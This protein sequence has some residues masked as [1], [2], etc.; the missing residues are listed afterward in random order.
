V[1]AH[2]SKRAGTVDQS[3]APWDPYATVTAR[4]RVVLAEDS[5]LVREG[6]RRILDTDPDIEL[7]SSCVDLDGLLA[8]VERDRPHVVV[9]D[10]RMPPGN[11]DEG[12][13]AAARLRDAH[14]EVGVVVLSQHDE[15]EYALRLF[16]KGSARRAYLLKDSLNDPARLTGAV[17][18][19]ARGGSVVDPKVVE[20]LVEARARQHDSRIQELTERERDVLS[21]MAQGRNNDTIAERLHLSVRMVEKHINS[22]FSKL[23]LSEELDVHRRVKAVLIYLSETGD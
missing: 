20:T 6:V 18:E 12:I 8:A 13:R 7:T 23:R 1:L 21:Q 15:P 10:I 19:V 5:Y 14:P 16:D 9:T 2:H 11:A 17:R 4:L 22:I 3:P